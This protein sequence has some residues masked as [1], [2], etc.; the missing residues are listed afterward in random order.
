MLQERE[1]AQ[2]GPSEQSPW[3]SSHLDSEA[4]QFMRGLALASVLGGLAWC[5]IL[6][7]AAAIL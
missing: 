2:A 3:S 7:S 1:L 5:A 6:T 4:Q